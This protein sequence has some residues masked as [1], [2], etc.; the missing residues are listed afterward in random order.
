VYRRRGF[1]S[2]GGNQDETKSPAVSHS[3]GAELLE[4]GRFVSAMKLK[5]ITTYV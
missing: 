1:D 3:S 2:L 4:A 5:V